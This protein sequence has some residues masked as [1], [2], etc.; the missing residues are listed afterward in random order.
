MTNNQVKQIPLDKIKVRDDRVTPL[1]GDAVRLIRQSVDETGHIRDA[2]HVRKIKGG[3]ELI[4]GRHRLEVAHSLRMQYIPAI[5]WSCSL[6]EARLMEADANL[7]FAHM[8]A[9]DLAVSLAGRKAAWLKL[10]PETAR[11][12]AGASSR[13]NMQP[14][15]MSFAEFMSELIGVSR[16][17]IERITSAGEA[18][19]QSAVVHL[20]DAPKR[21]VMDDLYQI[22]KAESDGER[23]YIV[24]M[25]AGGHV[26]NAAAARRKWAEVSSGEQPKVKDPVEEAFKG[27]LTAWKRAPKEACR[28]FVEEAG[29]D[30][31]E[32]V[33][34]LFCDGG[35]NE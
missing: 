28:R 18:L 12:V 9:V 20:R 22:A 5:V 1:N 26:K 6:D 34:D 15:E 8:G 19:D 2:I 11:G 23:D 17:Q 35:D 25:L 31:Y 32:M 10:H 16:R 30:L 29:P 14:T 7:T 4:D 24:K 3:Y 33:Q 13:W 21:V 27:L